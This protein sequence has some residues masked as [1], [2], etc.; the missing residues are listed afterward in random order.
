MITAMKRRTTLGR[1]LRL[2]VI[3]AFAAG[4]YGGCIHTPSGRRSLRDFD[5]D[6]MAALELDMWQAYYRKENVRLFRGLL[7]TLREQYR[8]TWARA[9]QAAFHLARAASTFGN[10]RSDYDRVIPDLERAYAIARDWTGSRFEPAAVARA[11]L[12]WWIARRVPGQDSAEQVGA[13]IADEYALLYEVPRE[14]VAEAALLRARAARLRDE[15]GDHADWAR[16]SELLQRSYWALD[17]ALTR[18]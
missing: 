3:L 9:G 16:V 18:R 6:R 15:G 12:A 1:G 13:L 8:Y 10:A 11:E 4:A 17:E 2:A 7:T 5:P 14:R